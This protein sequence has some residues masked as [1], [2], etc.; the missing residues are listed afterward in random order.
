MS[1]APRKRGRPRKYD[2]PEAKARQDVIAK[3]ARRQLRNPSVHGHVRFQVYALQPI[4]ALSPSSSPQRR[5]QSTNCPDILVNVASRPYETETSLTSIGSNR[6]FEMDSISPSPLGEGTLRSPV[7]RPR[8][9]QRHST[10]D[11]DICGI[12]NLK[13][14]NSTISGSSERE[15]ISVLPDR[16]ASPSSDAHEAAESDWDGIRQDGNVAVQEEDAGNGLL[17]D[18]ESQS[19]DAFETDLSSES[20]VSDAESEMDINDTDIPSE[21]DLYL[22]KGFLERTWRR[23]CDCQEQEQEISSEDARSGISL[24][25]MADYWRNLAVPDAIGIASPQARTDENEHVQPDWFS[26]LSGGDSRPNLNIQRS[27]A[28]PSDIQRTWDVDSVLCW[29]SC[30]SITRGLYVSYHPPV[31]RNLGSSIHVFHHGTALHLIPHLRLGSGR[32]SPQFSVYVF[33]PGI[34]HVCRTTTY[35]TKEEQRMW[36]DQL[37]LPA[38]RRCCPPDVI[39]HHPRSFDDV[40]S[41]AYSRQ[42]ETCGGM[43][44]NRM[45][46]HH[47][48]PQEYLSAIWHH[49]TQSTEQADFAGFRGMFIVLSAK[50]IKLEAKSST[51]QECRTKIRAHLHQVLDWSK[52]DLS[53]TWVD[54]GLEN[55]AASE[56]CTFLHKSRCLASW[57]QSMRY[58]DDKPLISSEHFNWNLTGQ[59]GSAR[60]EIRRSHPLRKGG[61]A[62]AQ[63]YNVNKD[64]FST[65]SKRDSGLFGE[66]NLEGLT[67]PPSLLDAWIV[68]ARQYRNAGLATSLQ[69][70]P[71][72]K[73]LRKVFQAMKSRIRFALDGSME[74]SFGVRE[75]YR[76][77]WELFT[78]VDPSISRACGP[79]HPF[80]VLPTAHVNEFMRWEFNRWLSAIEFVRARGS[81][82]DA[83]WEDHQ[84]NMIMVTILLRSLKAS[85][86]CH[87]V[88]KRSQMFKGTYKNRQGKPLRGLDF[89]SSMR[90]TGLAWLPLDLFNWTDFHLH[91]NFMASTTFTFNG[92]QGVF[93]NWKDVESVSREYCKARELEDQLRASEPSA[94][95]DILD[96]MRKMIYRHFALQVIRKI[97]ST[98]P[99][100]DLGPRSE[101]ELAWEGYQGLSYDIVHTLTG[102]PPYLSFTRK[103]PHK[104]GRAYH[105]RVQGL[106][107][108]DD[109][110]ARTLW[111]HCYYRQL[112]RRFYASIKTHLGA[113]DAESWKGSLGRHALPHFWLIPHYNM[114]SLFTTLPKIPGQ[115]NPRRPF[116]SGLHQ[117]RKWEDDME[118]CREDRWLLGGNVYMSG[119]PISL[120]PEN[121][122]EDEA[123]VGTDASETGLR[124]S[125]IDF[126][127]PI[128]FT[129]IP[130]IIEEG[131]DFTRQL[132]ASGNKKIL[133]H[134]EHACDCLERALKDPLCDL[135]LMIV[136][137][138]TSSTDIPKLPQNKNNFEP[139]PGRNRQ[140]LALT[141]M[142]RML[143]FLYP[144]Y[145][146]WDRDDGM[147]LRIP[148]MMKRMGKIAF[149]TD[150]A[151]P[152]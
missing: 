17:S 117:W 70:A 42:R 141:L 147:V 64:L 131:L 112:A 137:T 37:L 30:L 130:R 103:G 75:E 24:K 143:W 74:T 34:S 142:T 72:L 22:A 107:D 97:C 146:P 55:I 135:L 151:T 116:I 11:D 113:A 27:Q 14:H 100:L 63:R 6:T 118:L 51:F 121:T 50:N 126:G 26:I 60:V 84:R 69:S 80:W 73:R 13:L 81:R 132:Y 128:P 90:Q 136:L 125:S 124:T 21:S 65:A 16:S 82:R 41:K 28:I 46:M 110:L 139:G 1:E 23:L 134:Y 5:Q 106:F 71:K 102:E 144:Q 149:E 87:H 36:I 68:A 108:W 67:C 127:C 31:S 79:H 86:N 98:N 4:C 35:L 54:V 83:N 96:R 138:F 29:A 61:I 105:D 150:P 133:A 52:A 49:M 18:A 62:Y 44:P 7:M 39:Q 10:R 145:F 58:S 111:D 32:Q 91:D 77:S 57:V 152:Y 53:N 9:D 148:E 88:A 85:V 109:G 19:E 119:F 38:I 45:D 25:H 129:E 48:L 115:L 94:Y 2:T 15:S 104:L 89:E 122:V 3:R 12:P 93:R 95:P 40:E 78:T 56:K 43:V 92:L 140:L 101:H 99:V 120:R 33:F 66:P 114:H 8:G 76:I 123:E 59:A 20:D 47:H